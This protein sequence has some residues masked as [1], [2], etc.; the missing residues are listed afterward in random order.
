MKMIDR[1]E[2]TFILKEVL[3]R[4]IQQSGENAA[5]LEFHGLAG[6]GKSS[7]LD[8]NHSMAADHN[9]TCVKISVQA[10]KPLGTGMR[11]NLMDYVVDQLMSHGWPVL[12]QYRKVAEL[13]RLKIPADGHKATADEVLHPAVEAFTSELEA[14]LKH[15]PVTALFMFD[16][17]DHIPKPVLSWLNRHV[18]ARLI[19]CR[20]LVVVFAGRKALASDQL[21]PEVLKCLVS[22]RVKPF[23][24]EDTAEHIDQAL[25]VTHEPKIEPDLESIEIVYDLTNGHPFSNLKAVDYLQSQGASLENVSQKKHR[26]G[27]AHHLRKDVL[28]QYVF[29]DLENH[30]PPVVELLTYT[31]RFDAGTLG[32]LLRQFPPAPGYDS[33]NYNAMLGLTADL[34]T[35]TPLVAFDPGE[36]AYKVEPLLAKIIQANDIQINNQKFASVH[37]FLAE[38]CLEMP[39]R[40]KNSSEVRNLGDGMY[41]L[42]RH[43]E[44]KIAS[45][46]IT[47]A[48][49]VEQLLRRF[50]SELH[51]RYAQGN[52]AAHDSLRKLED[53]LK[54]DK[55][56][57]VGIP[58][59]QPK[60]LLLLTEFIA[61]SL[62]VPRALLSLIHRTTSIDATLNMLN[63]PTV[64]HGFRNP[65]RAG[66]PSVEDIWNEIDHSSL[67]CQRVFNLCLPP[68]IQDQL[69][70]LQSAIQIITNCAEIPWELIHD[71]KEFLCMRLSV[72]RVLAMQ[73]DAAKHEHL[74]GPQL[75]FLIVADPT[76]DLPATREEAAA[77]EKMLA[78]RASVK[79]LIGKE[80][81]TENALIDL[82]TQR[83]ATFDVI[84]YA[85]HADF[86]AQ[87]PGESKLLVGDGAVYTEHIESSLKYC[88]LVFLNA[89]EGGRDQSGEFRGGYLGSFTEGLAAAFLRGGACGCIGPIWPVPD[90]R[91][92]DFALDFYERVLRDF[93]IGEALRDARQQSYARSVADKVW[94]A[95]TLHGDPTVRLFRGGQQND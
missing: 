4:A 58:D 53:H 75:R 61:D 15:D 29:A 17:T 30:L 84:H 33:A 35:R 82:L 57:A 50:R 87:H 59:A 25:N 39:P 36:S 76:D 80:Q 92:R 14:W 28:Y 68:K 6:I 86:N 93:S 66:Q 64:L 37:E 13:I 19:E 7:L 22:Y 51:K 62:P 18:F 1:L 43:L 73:P 34:T 11:L 78:G 88:P 67:A 54:S 45:G 85:G 60:L 2:E 72:G 27:L 71:G 91:A 49:A 8:R 89:C 24:L 95:Y 74:P 83:D 70:E 77:I 41:H 3:Q 42:A 9:V 52:A 12:S 21:S 55:E 31:R 79:T 63:Q 44:G 38:Y 48:G 81:V 46:Q 23:Q 47:K 20:N 65:G 94:A 69:R 10:L 90:S 56:L 26:Q 16:Q 32:D 5:F 40:L